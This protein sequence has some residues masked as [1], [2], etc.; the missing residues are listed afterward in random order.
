MLS[1]VKIC[2][3]V[4]VICVLITEVDDFNITV[5]NTNIQ[6][7]P[8]LRWTGWLLRMLTTSSTD[9]SWSTGTGRSRSIST[10]RSWST[11]TGTGMT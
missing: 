9:R 8:G 2:F 3:C 4:I 10:G 7:M 1:S 11:C 6:V 5:Y